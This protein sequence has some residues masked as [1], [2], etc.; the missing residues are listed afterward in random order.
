MYFHIGIFSNIYI[1]TYILMVSKVT[2]SFPF[3]QTIHPPTNHRAVTCMPKHGM[4][5][6]PLSSLALIR[7]LTNIRTCSEQRASQ[8]QLYIQNPDVCDV[9]VPCY[10][11]ISAFKTYDAPPLTYKC[12]SLFVFKTARTPIFAYTQNREHLIPAVESRS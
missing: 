12:E 7:P 2:E 5:S 4:Y 11:T 8:T 10:V 1:H 3:D 9:K 6:T